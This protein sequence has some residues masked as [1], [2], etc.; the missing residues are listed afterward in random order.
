M[1]TAAEYIKHL[2]QGSDLIRLLEARMLS[3]EHAGSIFLISKVILYPSDTD[4]PFQLR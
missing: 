3:D 4:I 1:V 2:N